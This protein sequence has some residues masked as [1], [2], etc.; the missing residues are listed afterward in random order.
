M[1]ENFFCSRMTTRTK[2]QAL[3]AVATHKYTTHASTMQSNDFLLV[4]IKSQRL[5][6]NSSKQR[7]EVNIEHLHLERL[8]KWQVSTMIA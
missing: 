7:S 5:E 8:Y 2:L 4:T 3:L 6:E 1:I